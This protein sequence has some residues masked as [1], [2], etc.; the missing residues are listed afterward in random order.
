MT[1]RN[2]TVALRHMRD[3]AAQATAIG[4]AHSRNDLDADF[5]FGMGIA[6]LVEVIG[7]A[8][9]RVSPA[10]QDAH[11]H[12]PWKQIVGT[13][14]RLVHGYDEIDFDILWRIVSV[15]LPPLVEQLEAI[16]A[17]ELKSGS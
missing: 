6:K 12:I 2:D 13:R 15:E 5:L 4:R 10:I 1:L 16:L 14:N 8:A 9:N 17:D 11:P 7:E 3:Y